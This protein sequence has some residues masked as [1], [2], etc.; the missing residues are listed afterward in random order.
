MR[1]HCTCMFLLCI[2]FEINTQLIVIKQV[3][4]HLIDLNYINK[5]NN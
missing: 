1:F 3:Q 2:K 4:V 5:Y